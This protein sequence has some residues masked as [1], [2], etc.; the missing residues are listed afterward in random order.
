M[1]WAR[2][3]ARRASVH[4]IFLRSAATSMSLGDGGAGSAT[5]ALTDAVGAG[6]AAVADAVGAPLLLGL[7]PAA[8]TR[9]AS[10]EP[11]SSSFRTAAVYSDGGRGRS[12]FGGGPFAE[13]VEEEPLL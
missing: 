2:Q 3:T 13:I 4:P 5:A 10:K 11:Q 8:T 12:G 1:G 7:S 9:T 6:A